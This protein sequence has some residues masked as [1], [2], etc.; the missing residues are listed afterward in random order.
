[1]MITQYDDDDTIWWCW[2]D[3]IYRELCAITDLR[4]CRTAAIWWFNIWYVILW[5]WWY[6]DIW[7]WRYDVMIWNDDKF[8][9]IYRELCAITDL[10]LA[11][12]RPLQPPYQTGPSCKYNTNMIQIQIQ[13]NY[14]TGATI[15]D[16]PYQTRALL[17]HYKYKPIQFKYNTITIQMRP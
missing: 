7:W 1:M 3:D 9:D 16:P 5:S 4:L 11:R 10:R 8:Y 15:A 6:D 2:Y 17:H 14:D 13:Y 12:H